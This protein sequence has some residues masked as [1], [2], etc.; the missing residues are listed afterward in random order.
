MSILIST[1]SFSQSISNYTTSRVTGINYNS[2]VPTGNAFSSWRYSG[3][4]SE[5]DN[6]SEATDIGFDFWY[7]GQ[8]YTQF[9]VSTNG[10][11][12]FSNSNDDGGP[13][14]DDYGYCNSQFSASNN[15][16]WLALAPFYDDMTTGSG[17]DPLGTSIKYQITGTVPNRVLTIEWAGMAV[18]GNTTPNLNF[19]VKLY[20]T[21]GRIE[22]EYGTMLAGT[23]NFSY[24]LGINAVSV[25]NPPQESQLKNQ[26]FTNTNIFNNTPQNNL[27]TV[28]QSNSQISFVPP[29]PMAPSGSLSIGTITRTGMT[30]SWPN[31]ANNEVGYVLY[32]STDNTN[33]FFYS[34]TA[35]NATS[36]IVTDLLPETTYYWKVHAVTEGTLSGSLDNQAT[37][38][39]PRNVVSVSSGRWDVA[40][41]WDCA[42]VPSQGDNVL[43]SNGHIV[44]LRSNN[45]ECNDLTIG[46]GVN[47]EARFTTNT[48]R[49]LTINGILT[50]NSGATFSQASNS[51]ATHMVNLRGNVVNNGTMN[52]SVDANSRSNVNFI[53][54]NG[55]QVL[56]GSGTNSFYTLSIDKGSKNN[57]L[58]IT[59]LNFSCDPNALT[60]A[61]GGTFRFSSSGSNTFQL[62]N[63]TRDIPS[64]SAIRMNSVNSVMQFAAGVN[65]VGD[66]HVENGTVE[67]GNAANENITSYGGL[68][69]VNGGVL[70][71]AGRYAPNTGSVSR[72]QQTGGTLVCPAVASTSTTSAPFAM[73]VA[74]SSMVI[75]GGTIV[76][77]REGG[78]GAQNL[79]YNTSGVHSSSVTGGTLQIGNGSTPPGQ[80]FLI[81]AA[82]PIGNIL[83]HSPN[84]TAQL[85]GNNLTVRSGVTLNSGA[86]NDGGRSI[87]FGGNWLNSGGTFNATSSGVVTANGSSQSITSNGNIFND[88]V[89]AGTGTKS[90][91][92]DITIN[93]DL[94]FSAAVVPFNSGFTCTLG[95]DWTNNGSFTRNGETI[96]FNGS[97]N[98]NISGNSLTNFT[99]ITVN[100]SAGRVLVG[101]LANL[102]GLLTIQSSS[103]F[104]ADGDGSGVLTLISAGD[105]PTADASIVALP[106]GASVTGNVTVQRYMAPEVPG[107][108]R[109]YRYISSPVS[110]QFISDWQDDFPITGSFADPSI[111]F[112]A[113]SGITSIC[114]RP[115]IPNSPSLFRYVEPNIG[116]G[117]SDMGWVAYPSGGLATAAPI[118]VGQGY[119]AFIRECT[120]PTVVEVRGQANQ[121]TISFNA[122]LS[123]T[124]N[125]NL[126]D[127]FNLVGNPFPCAVDWNINE[128]WT[129]TGISSVIYVSDNGG[130]GGFITYDHTDNVPMV[131]ATGQAFW[132]R[133]TSGTH[134]FSVNELAKTTNNGV[135]YRAGAQNKMILSMDKDGVTDKAFIKLNS[136]STGRLDDFD[137]P[138]LNN[139][140]FDISTLSEEG[141]SMAVNS[142]DRITC[143][144]VMPIRTKDMV[145]GTYHLSIERQ[146]EFAEYQIELYDRFE[147][148]VVDFSQV[149]DY[150]FTVN[151]THASKAADRFELRFSEIAVNID[152]AVYSNSSLCEGEG[153]EITVT[154]SQQGIDYYVTI[155]DTVVSD[156]IVGNGGPVTLMVPA[157]Y[158]SIGSN[159]MTVIALPACGGVFEL[160]INPEI[161]VYKPLTPVVLPTLAQ[162]KSGSVTLAVEEPTIGSIY[163]Y[164]DPGTDE[165]L[166]IGSTFITPELKKSK[167]YYVSNISEAGC[168]SDKV[169]V[170]ATIVPYDDVL[171]KQTGD[172]LIS[173]YNSG[174][175]WFLDGQLVDGTIGNS[176]V[177]SVSGVYSV[178]VQVSETCTSH[179]EVQIEVSRHDLITGE[180]PETYNGIIASPNPVEDIIHIRVAGDFDN[181]IQIANAYGQAVM[182]VTL[183]ASESGKYA[184]A[185]LNDLPAGLYYL[186][187]IRKGIPVFFKIIKR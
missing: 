156:A 138:K 36:S 61:S 91:Q 25:G 128:G 73:D 144:Q 135:F 7:N 163:W 141:I 68:L 32:Y 65:L 100:K 175:I 29:N 13:Q 89:L 114:G 38:L 174:N 26:R 130:N 124:N 20:E 30:L 1:A 115:I 83:V 5:D 149:S 134:N 42:C 173:N 136:L 176:I 14:C 50:I 127:G 48:S 180:L 120:N 96:L 145:N 139:A 97:G 86:L 55:N 157:S 6:R 81:N 71:I 152:L 62:F 169:E 126:E 117:T 77:Q 93:G 58:D 88:L 47:G 122:L 165:L 121:G 111:E 166:S 76:L 95:G 60:F 148:R 79:G 187:G 87:T 184:S 153:A 155:D 23:N 15:G 108:T 16:T 140:L 75:T 102:H 3:A 147:D 178:M 49:T 161:M 80:T 2:I 21:S 186:Q 170:T 146:G 33:F 27:T 63:S 172:T 4:F 18:Y 185:Q 158:L 82:A 78:S 99:N 72:Y 85:T 183:E 39:A 167:T 17:I 107:T 133:V 11:I 22:F 105:E 164:D 53:K 119:A 110:G 182:K 129:R 10:F 41:T 24:T 66:L 52:F 106:G 171:I 40:G 57:T 43:I 35:A 162:C 104:D 56:S 109:V 154:N 142:L 94:T 64:N 118:E 70:Q 92:D 159:Q 112:P 9:S 8:R 179:A 45:M 123:L 131:L 113:G 84:A 54:I 151:A 160:S 44:T 46:Q 37:T 98:Q 168:R 74:G 137:G 103:E 143:G 34:Q 19:Q 67:V 116:T 90:L 125:G 150:T 181:T 28:P 12:D 177:P 101:G 59:S 31:W 132:V 51:N 69:E